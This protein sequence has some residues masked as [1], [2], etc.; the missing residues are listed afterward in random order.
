[1]TVTIERFR[2]LTLQCNVE[3]FVGRNEFI[4]DDPKGWPASIIGR[5]NVLEETARS[6]HAGEPLV[7]VNHRCALD[8]IDRFY[9]CEREL[10]FA[11]ASQS[12]GDVL[13]GES[14]RDSAGGSL[15]PT[16]VAGFDVSLNRLL[17]G[18]APA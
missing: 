15:S 10:S 9:Y 4:G 17:T 2:V 5:H 18:A 11:I 14:R 6:L 13:A 12:E 3:F 7:G 16:G 1:M 8:P